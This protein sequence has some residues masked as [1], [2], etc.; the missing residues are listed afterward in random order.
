MV[1]E[2]EFGFDAAYGK[3]VVVPVRWLAKLAVTDDHSADIQ[4]A[5][6]QLRDGAHQLIVRLFGGGACP[7]CR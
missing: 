1:L 6:T 7:L 3:A 5:L 2:H 4:T